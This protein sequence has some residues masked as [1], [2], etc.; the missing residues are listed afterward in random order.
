MPEDDLNVMGGP[1]RPAR[2]GALTGFY[3]DGCCNTGPEDHGLHVVCTEVTAAFLAFARRE[4]NDLVTPVPQAGFPGLKPGDRWCVCAGTWRR[5]YEAGV[6]SPVVLAATHEET[7]AVLPISALRN[8]RSTFSRRHTRTSH[9]RVCL[10]IVYDIGTP[11]AGRPL[12]TV[13][14]L[15]DSLNRHALSCYARRRAA[16]AEL[17]PACGARRHVRP[18]YV[19]S[20]PCMP[21]RRDIQTGRLNF[22]HRGWGPLEPFDHSIADM[23][24]EQR[25]LHP[26]DHRP[27]PLLRGRRHAASTA[28]T[29]RGSSS[30]ARRRTSGGRA[31]APDVEALSRALPRARSMISRP[32]STRSCRTTSIARVSREDRRVPAGAVLRRPAR[33]PRRASCRRQLAA[34]SRMLRSARAVLRARALPRGAE[35]DAL[36]GKIFDWPS[37]GRADIDPGAARATARQLLR[38]RR[39]LRSSSRASCSTTSIAHDLW[40]DTCLIVSDRSR[41][42][43]RREGVPRQ[44]PSALLQRGGAHPALDRARRASQARAASQRRS[45]RPST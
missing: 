23:L 42:A 41:P 25:R 34:A 21:A 24:R 45:P 44:E 11:S 19:G 6:A 5:A 8:T 31:I 10:K 33:F 38:A 2:P 43:A 22:L 36:G 27:L 29:R 20:M 7:L 4:G 15:F 28:A 3:R 30:A 32:T 37:Y 9:V 17:R 13:F 35:P 26:P 12:K 39:R 14:L 1:R 16:D 18:H 40:R